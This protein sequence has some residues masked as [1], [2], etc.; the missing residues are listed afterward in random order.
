[1]WRVDALPRAP[2]RRPLQARL[3]ARR[4]AAAGANVVTRAS[5][6][7]ARLTFS[8]TASQRVSVKSSSST[9]SLATLSILRP[10]GS[11]LSLNTIGA[12]AGFLDA[13]T[14]P[15]TGTHTLFLD[16]WGANTGSVTL[17]LYDMPAD[18]SASITAGGSSVVVTLG[19]PGQNGRLWPYLPARRVH[20][21]L[22]GFRVVRGHAL[23]PRLRAGGGARRAVRGRLLHDERR[24]AAG[25]LVRADEHLSAGQ[26]GRPEGS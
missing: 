3:R 14:L 10:D 23:G 24:A 19:T 8:G 4:D 15:A 21:R 18:T 26:R 11:T 12:G 9:I 25:G 1:M 20:D 7:N 16:P 6:Q 5:G 2:A 22:P 17:Q 13:A